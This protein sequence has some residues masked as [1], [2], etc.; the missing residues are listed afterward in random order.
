[1]LTTENAAEISGLKCLPKHGG[2]RENNCLVT[3]PMTDQR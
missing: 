1:V 3:H 2:A